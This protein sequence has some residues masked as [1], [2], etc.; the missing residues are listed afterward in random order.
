M[1]NAPTPTL[2][3]PLVLPCGAVLPN[4]LAKAAM[5]EG[6]ADADNHATPRLERLYE[7]WAA[8]GAG[9]L[10]SGNIQ[11]DPWHLERPGNVVLA[12]ERGLAALARVA[13]AAKAGGARVWAQISHTGRQVDSAINPA[14]LA[15]SSV[16]IDVVRGAGFSFAP[17]RAMDEAEIE[18]TVG[19][20]AATARLARAAGFDGVQL[21][22]AHGYLLSQFLSPLSNRRAD[23]WGGPLENRARLLLETIAAV[24]AAVGA[25]FPIGV[26]L[27]A[28]DF[29]K[30]GFTNAECLRLVGWLD[31]SGLDLLELSGGSLEQPKQVGA[32]LKDEGEDARPASTVAREAYFIA[33][34]G[35]VRA[36][37]KAPVM[38][39]GGFRSA[40]AMTAALEAGELD[41][42]GLGRP[43][44][45]DPTAPARLLSGEIARAPSPEDHIGLFHLLAWNNVQIERLAD[46]LDPDLSIGGAQA[47]AAFAPR[48]A[49]VMA[50]LLQARRVR[51][52]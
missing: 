17:P 11:V 37:A 1:A 26:K 31:A 32:T 21:H 13:A 36:V 40:A 27:N 42:V 23:R 10:L 7:R 39:T 43:L 46:G 29:Q 16:E 44:I 2:S 19:Q 49:A 6:I 51:A 45:A 47:Q 30:G 52:A 24:R 35:A 22:A 14:P 9:L 8:S 33:F 4:R 50:A 38:V 34:A 3:T 28:S 15:P 12:D 20:F 25:D 48:E 41:V 5:S 18:R